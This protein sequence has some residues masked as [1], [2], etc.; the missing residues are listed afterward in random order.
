MTVI[1]RSIKNL[2]LQQGD[3][4]VV[5]KSFFGISDPYAIYLGREGEKHLFLV[6][7]QARIGILRQSKLNEFFLYQV[8]RR[9]NRFVGPNNARKQLV[10]NAKR[11]RDRNSYSLLLNHCEDYAGFTKSSNSTNTAAVAGGILGAAALI[12]LAA[13]LLG[14]DD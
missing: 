10:Q 12:A 9:I 5:N 4:V 7:D 11:R 2:R 8:P 1:D 6:R 3:A 14:G 13:I